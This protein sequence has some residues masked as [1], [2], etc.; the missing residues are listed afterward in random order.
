MGFLS[1]R[2]RWQ[3]KKAE[4]RTS[5]RSIKSRSDE[6]RLFAASGNEKS[7]PR[8]QKRKHFERSAF[9]FLELCVPQAER[10]AHFVRDDGFAL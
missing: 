3:I 8:N 2:C 4:K 5:E 10:D 6:R 9:S 7:H 1:L